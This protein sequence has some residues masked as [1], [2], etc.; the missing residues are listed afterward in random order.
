MCIIPSRNVNIIIIVVKCCANRWKHSARFPTSPQQR[1]CLCTHTHSI[2]RWPPSH[3]NTHSL[4]HHP[5]Q[6]SAQ[7]QWVSVLPG[8]W[9]RGLTATES[10]SIGCHSLSKAT[11]TKTQLP[12][13]GLCVPGEVI[14]SPVCVCVCVCKSCCKYNTHIKNKKDERKHKEKNHCFVS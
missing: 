7:G 11:V 8:L 3:A 1:F 10:F 9:G 12:L 5:K 6:D 2:Y 4:S 13:Q 14:L